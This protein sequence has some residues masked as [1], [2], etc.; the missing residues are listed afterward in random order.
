MSANALPKPVNVPPRPPRGWKLPLAALLVVWLVVWS[1]LGV[2]V[3][4]HEL[5]KGVPNMLDTLGRM[6]PPDYT[7]VTDIAV[8]DLPVELTL[9]QLFLPASLSPEL[10]SIKAAWWSNTFPQTVIGATIQTIQMAVAGT[11]VAI[12]AAFPLSFLAARNTSPHPAVYHGVKLLTNFL[13]TIPD[14]AA[15]LVLIAAIG[16]GPFAGTLAL[17]F[18]S[19]AGAASEPL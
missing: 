7:R 2:Q 16:L 18:H 5:Y 1:F 10:A 9:S 11:F 17:A 14:F 15:G 8:Y 12:F 13:R 3:D 6:L 19:V 4:L